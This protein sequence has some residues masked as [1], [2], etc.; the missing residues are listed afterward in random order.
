MIQPQDH[1]KS[2]MK[3]YEMAT[4][5]TR[6]NFC[7][8][9]IV[10]ASSCPVQLFRV[11]QSLTALP[12]GSQNN[13]EFDVSCEALVSYFADKIWSL[14]QDLSATVD[15]VHELE[16]LWPSLGLTLNHFILLSQ[17]E[18]DSSIQLSP[19]VQITFPGQGN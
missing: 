9:S 4:E 2:F 19:S 18:I 17:E 1:F 14:C 10:P 5:A 8:A 7:T 15:T 12:Q 3:I 13:K 11:S 6:R 16:A